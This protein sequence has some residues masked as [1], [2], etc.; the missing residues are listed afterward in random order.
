MTNRARGAK[1][2]KG[3]LVSVSGSGAVN[4]IT[5]QY[6]PATLK[7]TVQ[8]QMVGGDENDRSEAIRFTGAPVQVIQVEI[9]LDA[10]DQLDKGDPTAVQS[11]ISPQLSALELLAYPDLDQVNQ[12]QSLLESG[13]IEM[14]PLTA[15][16]ILFVWGPNRVLPVRINN[17]TITEEVFDANLNPI[18]AAVSLSMRVLNYSDL[19]SDNKEYHQFMVY[20]QNMITLANQALF[21]N[22]TGVNSGEF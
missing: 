15:P 11:G 6:N 16:R 4:M 8:P 5:F 20:Q 10:T 14:A 17:Y 3:A 21:I 22:S 13:I 2:L 12:N 18:Q 19:T 1:T 9:E 7:R